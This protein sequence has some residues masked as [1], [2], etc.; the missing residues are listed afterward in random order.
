MLQTFYLYEAVEHDRSFSRAFAAIASSYGD[1]V[2]WVRRPPLRMLSPLIHPQKYFTYYPTVMKTAPERARVAAYNDCWMRHR[3]SA[4][5]L[6]F[7]QVQDFIYS[8]RGVENVTALLRGLGDKNSV[9]L[10]TWP[11]QENPKEPLSPDHIRE[12]KQLS[13]RLMIDK[14]QFRRDYPA[15]SRAFVRPSLVEFVGDSRLQEVNTKEQVATAK[16]DLEVL[17]YTVERDGFDAKDPAR[18]QPF[19]KPAAQLAKELSQ[20]LRNRVR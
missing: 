18:W 1:S 12:S 4:A 11:M 20:R 19:P 13:H 15:G 3:N 14:Y 8:P 7:L 10:M 5:W 6:G 17:S 2:Q 16:I 9:E